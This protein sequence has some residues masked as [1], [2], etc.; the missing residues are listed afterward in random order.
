VDFKTDH[1]MNFKKYFSLPC[2]LIVLFISGCSTVEKPDLGTFDSELFISDRNACEGKRVNQID[3]LR[4]MKEK[5]LGL[6]ETQIKEGFGRYD[7]QILD[8]RSE[9]IIV[10]FLEKG[11]Q[12]EQLQQPSTAL[13]MELHI[14]AVGLVKEVDFRRGN[15]AE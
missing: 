6:S 15:P 7:Y 9:K 5:I 11:P 1:L 14:N 3:E 2:L 10:F 12:C 13:V 4:G 8:R